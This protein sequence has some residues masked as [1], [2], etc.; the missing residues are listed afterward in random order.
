MIYK[1][2]KYLLDDTLAILA[3]TEKDG[4]LEQTGEVT[5]NLTAYGLMPV[6]GAIFMPTYKMTNEYFDEVCK[7]LVKEIIGTVEVPCGI[8]TI[9]KLKPDWE[10]Y[11]KASK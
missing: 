1:K 3:F 5:V 8:C 10:N 2:E 9:A 7:D 4:Q 11:I 6:S